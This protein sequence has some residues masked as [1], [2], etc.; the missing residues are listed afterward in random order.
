MK[1]QSAIESAVVISFM[2][3]IFTMFLLIVT[4]RYVEIQEQKDRELIKDV[5]EVVKN[6]IDLALMAENG[7]FRSFDLPRDLR[8]KEYL[9]N[10]STASQLKA[11]FSELSIKYFNRSKE[12]EHVLTLP[13]NIEGKINKGKNNIS[14]QQ[15]MICLNKEVCK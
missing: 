9:I 6:E 12:F 1:A 14:K 15:G 13:K 7:Y 11:N 4:N 8:D 5:G 2:L 10:L 3:L